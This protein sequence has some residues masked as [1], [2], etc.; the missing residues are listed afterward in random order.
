MSFITTDRSQD[1]LVYING[2]TY[3]ISEFRFK[4]PGGRKVISLFGGSDAS[5]AFLTYHM[6]DFP[7][8]MM[9]KY[10]SKEELKLDGDG[11]SPPMISEQKDYL[12]LASM[13][14]KHLRDTGAGAGFAPISQWIKCIFLITFAVGLEFYGF[15]VGYRTWVDAFVLGVLFAGIGLCVQ[16][17]GSHSAYSS[18]PRLNELMGCAQDWIGGSS[19]SWYVEH[20]KNHHNYTNELSVD[21]DIDTEGALRLHKSHP[22][23]FFHKWQHFY[24]FLGEFAYSFVPVFFSF[25]ELLTGYYRL[26]KKYRMSSLLNYYRIEGIIFKLITYFRI[27]VLPFMI[28]SEHPLIIAVKIGLSMSVASFILAFLFILSHNFEGVAFY[29]KGEMPNSFL[30]RQVETSSDLGGPIHN[31]L[32][33]GLGNQVCHHLFP[34]IAHTHYESIKPIVK[35]YCQEHNI[36]YVSFDYIPENVRSVYRQLKRLGQPDEKVKS[37]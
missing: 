2:K 20:I 32:T 14:K 22:R 36:K 4:H 15:F 37:G 33:G 5:W 3:D 30:K 17:D 34:R 8:K 31:F 35:K 16:H 28:F 23:Y 27:L 6:R 19:L 21:P 26:N 11:K 29:E 18:N 13:V 24:L 10:L 7:E 9:E 25:A 12:E 1:H